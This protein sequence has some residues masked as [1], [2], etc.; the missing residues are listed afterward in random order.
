MSEQNMFHVPGV[1][2]NETLYV[3]TVY[4]SMFEETV[5][6]VRGERIC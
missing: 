2:L 5:S 4:T 3:C 1:G 6:I